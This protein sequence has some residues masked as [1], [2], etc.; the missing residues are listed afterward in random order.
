MTTTPPY[1]SVAMCTFQGERHLG[2]QLA[3]IAE[4]TRRPD[5]LVIFDD[6]SSDR[7]LAI[8]RDFAL[9]APFEVK[10][11]LNDVRLGTVRNFEMAI[12]ACRGEIVLLADQDDLWYPDKTAV[13]MAALEAHPT[14]GY[15]FSDADLVGSELEPL[16]LR[17]WKDIGF[18]GARVE[19][20]M[21]GDQLATMVSGGSFVYG[22][23]MAFR[24]SH[25]AP[26]LPISVRSRF[27]THD[28]WLA[29]V[30]SGMGASGIAVPSPLLQYRQHPRQQ[31][32]VGRRPRLR[33]RL[34]LALAPRFAYCAEM[35]AALTLIRER[36]AASSRS[37]V[38]LALLDDCIEHLRARAAVQSL[39][40][41]RRL[42]AVAAELRTR[43]YRRF[44]TSWRSALKDALITPSAR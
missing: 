14:A 33:E 7:T 1:V 38:P 10:I 17:L 15:A 24:R 36:L 13:L 16:G 26:A 18:T 21:A 27:M 40:G 11:V 34:R 43:R 3:S 39:R 44:S 37:D 29:L 30:M 28:T 12:A 9:A 25:A 20:F 23:T 35:A 22:N 2:E 4:Q 19:R 5:E 42:S 6:R 31:S 8:A 32:G 41:V